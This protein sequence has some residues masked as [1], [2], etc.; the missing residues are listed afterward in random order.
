MKRYIII[1]AAVWGALVFGGAA[2][3]ASRPGEAGSVQASV[4]DRLSCLECH[5]DI[6]GIN[7]GEHRV[8]HKGIACTACHPQEPGVDHGDQKRKDCRQCHFPHDE[9]VAHDAHLR[10]SC[11]ACH[12]AGVTPVWDPESQRVL[13]R[14]NRR[15]GG[16]MNVHQ[17]VLGRDKALCRRCHVRGNMIGAAAGVLPPKSVICM[18]CHAAT[19][20]AGDAV[21][22]TALS[23]FIL[24]MVTLSM[25]WVSGT[26]A[27]GPRAGNGTPGREGETAIPRRPSVSRIFFILKA[28]A[29]DVF[30]QRRLY[31]QSRGR[32]LIHGL[33]FFPL[34][35]RFAWGVTALTASLWVP[36]WPA[37]WNMLDKNNPAG[38][39]LFDLSGV[40]IVL[41]LIFTLARR[42]AQ[43][44][45]RSG[46]PGPDG[47]AFLLAGGIMIA[48]FVLEGMRLAMTGGPDGA[49]YAFL[50][51]VISMLFSDASRLT[52]V[53]G[54]IW[55]IHAIL[56]G[57]FVAYLPFSRMFHIIMAPVVLAMNAVSH[58]PHGRNNP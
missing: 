53:Y 39:F 12:L 14:G 18:P 17:M 37:A 2:G 24:G 10:V 9:K 47:P 44:K 7:T 21:S 38:A 27:G 55:Y 6:A 30:L 5:E 33:I 58:Y 28:V 23:L 16:A 13:W 48:G 19:F 40:M 50:G 45:E 20:S 35:F 52:E 32:W 34:A 56:T 36:G 11:E 31:R 22:V 25:V 15:S 57:A 41:G 1:L 4:H 54:Y 42:A 43:Q 3:N 29:L 51:Y 49:E 26:Q 8:P 46:L